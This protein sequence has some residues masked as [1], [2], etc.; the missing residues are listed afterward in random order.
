MPERA[1]GLFEL[2]SQQ[3]REAAPLLTF[4]TVFFG[5]GMMVSWSLVA[6]ASACCGSI[7]VNFLWWCFRA[8]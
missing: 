5:A 1:G 4:A 7:Q 2:L 3:I 6:S 8:G